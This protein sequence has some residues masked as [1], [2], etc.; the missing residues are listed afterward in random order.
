ML[1]K[2]KLNEKHKNL[3][4]KMVPFAGFEM[5]LQYK[6]ILYEHKK[7]RGDV[8]VFD[9]SHMGEI[10]VRG[11]DAEKFV[12]Y[13]ITN[14]VS[15]I[16]SGQV[17]YSV[18]CKEDGGI[19]DDLLVYKFSAEK[20]LLVVNAANTEK[21]FNWIKEKSDKFEVE[22]INDSYNIS[23]IAL[24]G[25]NA[26]NVLQNLVKIP[27]DDLKYYHFLETSILGEE[28]ILSRTGYTG[29]DG[30]EIYTYGDIEKI[31]DKLLSY[32]VEPCGLGARDT[33]R[34]EAGYPLYGNDLS[35]QINPL[36]ASLSWVVKFDKKEFIGKNQLLEIKNKGIKFK[37]RG[38]RTK[39]IREIPRHGQK[40]FDGEK[41]IGWVSSGN[42][43]PILN[44]GIG[45]VYVPLEYKRGKKV[46]VDVRGKRVEA[47]IVKMPF[48]KGSVKKN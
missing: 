38:I 33:L 41:E 18:M 32:G 9:V 31:W 48:V 14:D 43:S 46:E 4:A 13:I 3:G 24:Q 5:P 36:E 25:P 16:S 20:I 35:E 22:V 12:N 34:L 11:K 44:V 7:V 21:D 28:V 27:L 6:G 2:T 39:S 29:E 30:F 8:G 23:E 26:Q 1:K 10:W 19:I 42:V 40:V 17:L 47:E 37:R 45:M 15:R